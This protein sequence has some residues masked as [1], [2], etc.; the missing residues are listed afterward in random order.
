MNPIDFELHLPFLITHPLSPFLYY[1]HRELRIKSFRVLKGS[2]DRIETRIKNNSISFLVPS[3]R[4]RER[5]QNFFDSMNTD[6][7]GN[8]KRALDNEMMG[9]CFEEN[10][11]PP[12]LHIISFLMKFVLKNLIRRYSWPKRLIYLVRQSD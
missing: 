8:N 11:K 7:K 3:V 2:K 6:I 4:T 1:D 9:N 10:L 12:M 5:D